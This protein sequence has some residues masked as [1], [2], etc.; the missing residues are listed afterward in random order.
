[1]D[2]G[3]LSTQLEKLP[4]SGLTLKPKTSSL[5]FWVYLVFFLLI[6]LAL[7]LLPVP[8]WQLWLMIVVLTVY[9]QWIFRKHLLLNHPDSIE[10]LVFTEL[11]WCA[12]QLKNSRVC[13]ADILPNTFIS[14][15]LVIVN[16]QES[17]T[18]MEP[19]TLY[20]TFAL[21]WQSVKSVLPVLRNTYTVILTAESIGSDNFRQLKRYLRFRS[22]SRNTDL[23][24]KDT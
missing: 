7:V 6:L 13:K 19:P 24:H 9:C 2:S 10:K 21:Y 15:F 20:N 16:L 22:V 17:S 12:L 5:L 11:N 23:I 3:T 8:S 18:A 14:E 1:M 4:A